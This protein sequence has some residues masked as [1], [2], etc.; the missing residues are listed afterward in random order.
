MNSYQP[1]PRF[2]T[3]A[4]SGSMVTLDMKQGDVNGDGVLDTVYLIG[5]KPDGPSGIYAD[6]ISVVIQDGRSKQQTAVHFQ[7]NAGYNARLFLGDFDRDRIPDILVS[8]DSGGSGGYGFFYMYSFK[9]NML[10]KMFDV[11][12]YNKTYSFKVNYE[13]NYKVSV[14]NAQLDV[15]FLLDISLK[16]PDYLAALYNEN[17]KL[18]KPIQGQVLA[19]GALKPIIADEK[20]DGYDL[21]A[22]QRIIGTFNA[23]TLGYVENILTWM[24]TGFVSNM[25]SV[26]ILGSKLIA[27]Y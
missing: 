6:H 13:D 5:N 4:S 20:A 15:L 14:S 21:L 9:N 1:M 25:L 8:I 16:G 2:P 27:L 11:D 23:D 3:Q 19:L 18:L 7:N 10:R 12:T 24:G 17:G 26:S 22:I